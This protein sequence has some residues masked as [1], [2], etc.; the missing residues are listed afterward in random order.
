MKMLLLA[1][2][3]CAALIVF[4]YFSCWLW[5]FFFSELRFSGEESFLHMA[6]RT[7]FGTVVKNFIAIP[8]D[9]LMDGEFNEGCKGLVCP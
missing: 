2:L 1:G 9:N 5:D 7:N 4:S 6:F 3:G 8:S